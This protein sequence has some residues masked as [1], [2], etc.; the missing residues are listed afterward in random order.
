MV[1]SVTLGKPH[2]K[3]GNGRMQG[4]HLLQGLQVVDVAGAPTIAPRL[5][6]RL[7]RLL[8][9]DTG[10][11]APQDFTGRALPRQGRNRAEVVEI[12]A[13]A[14]GLPP[15][16]V[17]SQPTKLTLRPG[18][19][20]AESVRYRAGDLAGRPTQGFSD[21]LPGPRGVEGHPQVGQGTANARAGEK[22][23]GYCGST[24]KTSV[25]QAH[26]N[27]QERGVDSGQY[28]N[29]IG[30]QSPLEPL[31]DTNYPP[32]GHVGAVAGFGRQ[33]AAIEKGRRTWTDGLGEPPLIV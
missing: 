27:G 17:I 22:R 12:F 33:G 21:V 24:R 10:T 13:Q 16:Q 26:L 15:L 5:V 6:Q 30:R 32:V 19:S 14:L 20:A 28:R 3:G 4:R 2:F 1:D 18:G 29:L 11:Q 25:Q 8:Q 7:Q 31:L 23:P 9:T